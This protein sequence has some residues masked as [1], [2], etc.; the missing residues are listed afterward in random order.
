MSRRIK[1]LAQECGEFASAHDSDDT[2]VRVALD[3]Q[4]EARLRVVVLIERGDGQVLADVVFSSTDVYAAPVL[5][6]MTPNNAF[7]TDVSVCMNGISHFHSETWCPVTVRLRTVVD[8]MAMAVLHDSAR[9]ELVGAV[10]VRTDGKP[11]IGDDTRSYNNEH[12]AELLSL[13]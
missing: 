4:D 10:G 5:R 6:F 2:R 12:H 13:F 1:G 11:G 9:E 8:T 7:L 3:R